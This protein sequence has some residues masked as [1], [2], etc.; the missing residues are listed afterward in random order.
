MIKFYDTCSLLKCASTLS[1]TS[2]L[3]AIS[4]I[5]LEELEHIKTST[6][7][8]NDIKYAAREILRKLDKYP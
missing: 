4:S 5:S 3:F 1:D 2:E 6:N 8:D 7:K